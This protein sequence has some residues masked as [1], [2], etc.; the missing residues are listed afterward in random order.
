MGKDNAYEEKYDDHYPVMLNEMLDAL[1]VKDG[2]RYLDCTFGAGGYSRAILKSANCELVALDQDEN[3]KKYVPELQREFGDRFS[4]VLTNF[5]DALEKLEGQE[6]DGIVMDLGVSSMQLDEGER[7]FSFQA[8]GALD[9]RMSSKGLSAA[10]FVNSAT[11][12]EIA[13]VIYEYGDETES[14][15][16]ARA[17]VESRK[18]APLE[19]TLQLADIVR[20]AKKRKGGKIDPATKTFQAIRIY[21]NRELDVL[22]IF[23][24]KVQ[25]LLKSGGR[26][27]V[28]SF[29][30]LEDTIVKNFFREN[31]LKKVARS[32]YDKSKP[33]IQPG[34]WL[35][36]ISRKAIAPS[37]MEV[38]ENIRSRSAKLR[39]AEKLGDDYAY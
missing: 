24:D 3:A 12:E 27:V 26:L 5:A 23:L 20:S 4:F 32:K 17:I 7:G 15:R 8:D 39:V 34:K 28:V 36:L 9:M 22:K 16:I 13:N 14:R 29:H 19:R 31:A 2:G 37:D 18:I 25:A 35:Q 38:K 6:F 10:D 21:V 30:S 33:E 11:E 1:A